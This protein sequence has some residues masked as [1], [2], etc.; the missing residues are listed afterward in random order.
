MKKITSIV[1]AVALAV[2]VT[3]A[4]PLYAGADE[5]TVVYGTMNIPY[6]DFYRAE[7]SGAPIAYKVDAV[8]SATTAKWSKNG[9][10]ELFEGTYNQP[11][12]DGTGTILGVTYPVAISQ[13]DL[14]ALG[15]DNY[16]FTPLDTAP[17]AYKNV[18][19]ENGNAVFSAV[20]D[21]TPVTASGSSIK[22]GT[23]TP[24]GD[25]IIDIND[26][27]ELGAIYGALIRTA[28]GNAYAMVHE[29][30]IWRGELAWSSGIKTS[31]PHGNTLPYENFVGLMGSLINE[32]V[33]ITKDGYTTIPADTYVP[34]KFTG[35]INVGKG[36]S[37]TGS[38]ELSTSG[39]PDDYN[40]TYA[41]GDNFTVTDTAVS[42]N[43]ALPGTYTLTISDDS[44]KYADVS[45][46]FVLSTDDM[47][48]EF[49]NGSLVKA[50]GADEAGFANF[51]K[52]ISAVSV[53]GNEYKSS[54]KGSVK[55]IGEDGN[56]D[57]SA[58]AKGEKVFPE[59]GTYHVSVTSAGYNNSLEFDLEVG[60]SS[61]AD[62]PAQTI[63]TTANG[64][65][66]STTT[67][68]KSSGSSAKTTAKTTCASAASSAP[69]TGVAGAAVPFAVM[70]SAAVIAAAS[71][72]KRR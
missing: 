20:Q 45:A 4:V 50:K 13:K 29:L 15:S 17:A 61:P 23:S 55:I 56:I 64:S 41:V 30:N 65:S 60:A 24:W 67:S 14:T 35:E 69:K 25:Y 70:A 16:G 54:G 57:I 46:D 28:D 72:K 5:D 8:S 48:A 10:G 1:S 27:P 33:F 62:Q 52:N 22:L 71:K 63:T 2:S 6:A 12:E 31:E 66:N 11:N 36:S 51:M 40:K 7:L 42:Y 43:N 38:V 9:E 53:N 18:T 68:T 3:C 19:V 49:S 47:P 58:S 59:N 44:G 21:D 34:V 37:G 39:F 26:A 32:V